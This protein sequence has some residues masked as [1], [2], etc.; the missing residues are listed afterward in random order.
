MNQKQQIE[1]MKCPSWPLSCASSL[2]NKVIQLTSP[3]RGRNIEISSIRI[4]ASSEVITSRG[5]QF[6]SLSLISLIIGN[7]HTILS[8][9]REATCF[10]PLCSIGSDLTGK[11]CFMESNFFP[12]R[13]VPFSDWAWCVEKQIE[14]HNNCFFQVIYHIHPFL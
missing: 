4:Y 8:P 7:W 1:K 2:L 14:A 5:F 10:C 6:K 9:A 11:N 13:V 3:C 12:F